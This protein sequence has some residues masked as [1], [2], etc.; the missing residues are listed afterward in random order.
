MSQLGVVVDEACRH[1]EMPRDVLGVVLAEGLEFVPRR[2]GQV[3]RRHL[4]GDLRPTLTAILWRTGDTGVLTI[5]PARCAGTGATVT[6]R[7]AVVPAEAALIP[8]LPGAA[9][10]LPVTGVGAARVTR[11]TRVVV[12]PERTLTLPTVRTVTVT[13]GTRVVVT[14]ERTLTLPT[15]RTV[16]ITTVRTVTITRRT[17]IIVTPERTLTLPTVRTVT[18]TR[19]TRI[20]VTPER[21]LT[22]PTVRTVTITR[23]T[24]VIVTPERTLTLPT[25]R[26]VTITRRTRVGVTPDRTGVA[27]TGRAPVGLSA[28]RTVSV[29]ARSALASGRRTPALRGPPAI[30]TALVRALVSASAIVRVVRRHDCP[31]RRICP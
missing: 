15:V 14:P 18:I 10:A 26:T 1:G 7:S 17:R 30:G 20:I 22:L 31:S 13:R 29:A 2:T 19:R 24:R 4:F 6:R 23:R 16:T 8:L 9:R 3:P 27:R 28:E 5:E 11:R 25:V 21:T 12:T